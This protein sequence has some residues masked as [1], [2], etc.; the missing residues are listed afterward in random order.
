MP[1]DLVPPPQHPRGRVGGRD[2]VANCVGCVPRISLGQVVL[3]EQEWRVECWKRE[4]VVEIFGQV[5]GD[6]V[7]DQ[8]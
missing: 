3:L 7:L 2:E 5:C 8:E 4:W 6:V 1:P